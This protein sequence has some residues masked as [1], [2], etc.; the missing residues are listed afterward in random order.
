[1]W[2]AKFIDVFFNKVAE[3]SLRQAV[4]HEQDHHNGRAR[5]CSVTHEGRPTRSRRCRFGEPNRRRIDRDGHC[6]RCE[7]GSL[8]ACW[9]PR[10]GAANGTLAHRAAHETALHE[11]P[12]G[13]SCGPL[14]GHVAQDPSRKQSD[15]LTFRRQGQAV[16]WPRAAR[17]R[18]GIGLSQP[19]H[20]TRILSLRFHEGEPFAAG[21]GGGGTIFPTMHLPSFLTASDLPRGNAGKSE[22]VPSAETATMKAG[23]IRE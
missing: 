20:Y 7:T 23:E 6:R 5:G 1:M 9:R 13:F 17:A 10:H 19:E 8:T 4:Q 21:V 12:K 18:F 16:P 3:I 11:P 22:P 15:R 2:P 14:P